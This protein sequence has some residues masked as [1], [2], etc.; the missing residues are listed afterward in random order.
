MTELKKSTKSKNSIT[1]IRGPIP[2][3][4][5]DYSGSVFV[6]E[7]SP[8]Q[9]SYVRETKQFVEELSYLASHYDPQAEEQEHEVNSLLAEFQ[10]EEDLDNPYHVQNEIL[11]LLD[12]A[13]LELKRLIQ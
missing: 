1:K 5:L 3:E 2:K 10:I 8:E 12:N 7:A 13:Q 11:I 4:T 6:E 9:T